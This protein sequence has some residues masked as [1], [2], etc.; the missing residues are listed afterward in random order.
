MKHCLPLL[1]IILFFSCSSSDDETIALLDEAINKSNEDM[2]AFSEWKTG[3]LSLAYIANKNKVQAA[4]SKAVYLDS[5]FSIMYNAFNDIQENA[6]ITNENSREFIV[7]QDLE[8]HSYNL[9]E[10]ISNYLSFVD[11]LN[12]DSTIT[13]LINQ[14][15][16]DKIFNDNTIQINDLNIVINKLNYV[17]YKL[18]DSLSNSVK[19]IRYQ[20]T[21]FKPGVILNKRSFA[22]NE[23]LEAEIFY[24]AVDTTI[25][26]E[27]TIENQNFIS[28]NSIGRFKESYN[29]TGLRKLKGQLMYAQVNSIYSDSFPII[30]EYKVIK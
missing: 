11:E 2:F 24:F 29:K 10:I 14:I 22:F 17:N 4:Y 12:T 9:T 6:K 21:H 13:G 28:E 1:I 7:S 23:T 20:M 8:I 25:D 5:L 27:C 15:R 19:R 18:V 16:S 30:I 26:F 3:E